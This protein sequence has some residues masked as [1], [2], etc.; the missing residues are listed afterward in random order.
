[1]MGEQGMSTQA[2]A[3]S[4]SEDKV[5]PAATAGPAVVAK[6][7]EL[8]IGLVGAVGADL[9]RVRPA[10]RE[11]LELLGYEVVEVKVT[12]VVLPAV[13]EIPEKWPSAYER[14]R[15]LMDAG[16]E[17]RRLTRD[18]AILANGAIAFMRSKR[19]TGADGQ[20][21]PSPRKAYIISSLK[22]PAEV[23]MFRKTY[24]LGF[25][26][27]G[28]H[29]DEMAR[30]EW[31]TAY[32]RMSPEQA[33][34]LIKRDQDE[35]VDH[36]QKVAETFHLADMFV[37]LGDDHGQ[38]TRSIRRIV[39]LMFGH[40]FITPT[41]DEYAMFLA[42]AASLRS[43]D[44]SRQVGA[45][46]AVN[47]QVVATGANDCPKAGGGLYWPNV[48]GR[49]GVYDDERGR[50]Y[51]RGADSNRIEQQ[52]I[53]DDIVTRA[54]LDADAEAKLRKALDKSRV[55]DLTEFGRVVHA[56]MEA[57]LSCA[58]ARV[59]VVD[60]HLFSTTFPCHNC[61]KHIIAA[62]IRRV[63]FIEP[64]PKSKA[65]EFH[66]DSIE[67]LGVSGGAADAA[68]GAKKVSFEPFVGVGPRRFVDLFS[69]QL[70]SG[71]PVKRKDQAGKGLAWPPTVG[72]AELRLQML[73]MSYLELELVAAND[74]NAAVEGLAQAPK[75]SKEQDSGCDVP[76]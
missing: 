33:D 14:L 65:A 58:R 10:I 64:Y 71:Y 37:H 16:N 68:V 53:I 8:V 24:P 11:V 38:L 35:H 43:A 61:A 52:R 59:P 56:E 23:R 2:A 54:D 47:E 19:A 9:N 5:A 46:I 63:V 6:D 34:E 50:D 12:D 44:L 7:A 60:G 25:F 32:K 39:E 20:P 15:G 17:A 3:S 28:I 62:G 75:E 31:L 4:K 73:P 27:V 72:K 1:M 30:R 40:P 69:T 76:S 42:F 74:F 48:V 22:H 67:L 49:A 66:D 21:L 36:G 18:P 26:L 29:A 45:V 57:L 70:G 41:F 55:R 13:V 51:M